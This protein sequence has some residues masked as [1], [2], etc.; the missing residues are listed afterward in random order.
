MNWKSIVKSIAPVLGTALGGPMAGGAIKMLSTALLGNENANEQ[1]LE[2]FILGANPDQLLQ[3]KQLDADFKLKMEELGVDVFKLEVQD[4][5][6]ARKNHK[7]SNMPAILCLLLTAMVA[8]GL[9]AL[10]IMVIPPDNANIIYMVFGQILTAWTASI[11]YWVGT[12]KSSSDK[13]KALG[14]VK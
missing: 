8:G 10:L 4:R 6:S 9:A 1:E 5:D 12:T 3:I 7:D 13:N 14:V 11:A 2:S